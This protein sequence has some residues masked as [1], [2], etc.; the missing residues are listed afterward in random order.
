MVTVSPSPGTSGMAGT[1][2]AARGARARLTCCI[3]ISTEPMNPTAG[4]AEISAPSSPYPAPKAM[5]A[6]MVAAMPP[7]DAL[8]VPRAEIVDY[9]TRRQPEIV[10]AR[11]R[12]NVDESVA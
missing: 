4:H 3:A 10:A 12:L 8:L 7:D 1:L 9:W 6:L 5:F 2:V 11:G